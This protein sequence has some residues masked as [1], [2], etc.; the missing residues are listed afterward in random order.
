[1]NTV[2]VVFP[3]HIHTA[4]ASPSLWQWDYGQRLIITGAPLPDSYEVHFCNAGDEGTKSKRGDMTGVDIPDEYLQTGKN[5]FA[6]IYLHTGMDD[7]ETVYKITIKVKP[8]ARPTEMFLTD[9]QHD[10][11][12]QAIAQLEKYA[13]AT[14]NVDSV[15]VQNSGNLITSGGVYAAMRDKVSKEAGKVLSSND[16]TDEYKQTLDNLDETLGHVQPEFMIDTEPTAGSEKLISSGAVYDAINN[17]QDAVNNALASKQDAL[18]FDSA[19]KYGS[20]NPVTSNGVYLA[21]NTKTDAP[22][23]T[24]DDTTSPNY[25]RNRTHYLE[26]T[27]NLRK[28]CSTSKPTSSTSYRY[29]NGHRYYLIYSGT[30]SIPCIY[31]GTKYSVT[32]GE[33]E[34]KFGARGTALGTGPTSIDLEDIGLYILSERDTTLS[35]YSLSIYAPYATEAQTIRIYSFYESVQK[36]DNKYL[37]LSTTVEPGNRNPVTSDAVYYAI[38]SSKGTVDDRLSN[39]SENPVQNKVIKAA[40]D[41][42]QDKLSFDQ[43]PAEN[44]ANPITSAGVYEAIADIRA[45]IDDEL[46]YDSDNP[47]KN[48]TITAVINGLLDRIQELED[49]IHEQENRLQG[50]IDGLDADGD[51]P[52]DNTTVDEDGYI[53]FDPSSDVEVDSDGYIVIG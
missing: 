42:K 11:L 25:I 13:N 43:A 24:E 28:T 2:E 32:M 1:M 35:N 6:Y 22:D 12:D 50:H 19:P 15:P 36:L 14:R 46:L 3:D 44:S 33:Q 16:F 38:E 5:I 27:F 47:V 40:I 7:G 51:I 17:T 45:Q 41:K 34:A 39:I 53:V 26:E 48:R 8:R 29:F 49:M 9:V 23:W 4:E 30:E 21:L 10:A 37:N 31:A 18:E 52:L 20:S